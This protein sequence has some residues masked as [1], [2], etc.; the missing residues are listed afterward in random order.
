MMEFNATKATAPGDAGDTISRTHTL[1]DEPERE[2][3]I[4]WSFRKDFLSEGR[5]SVEKD[6]VEK[7]S[8][9]KDFVGKGLASTKDFAEKDSVAR[10]IQ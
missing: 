4:S 5:D 8:V 1:L 7:D 2:F 6:S 10:Y 9:E 3:P